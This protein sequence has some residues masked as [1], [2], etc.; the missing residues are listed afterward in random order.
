MSPSD[1]YSPA[2]DPNLG[3]A[4]LTQRSRSH[5]IARGESIWPETPDSSF[6]STAGL[7]DTDSQVLNHP[8]TV[9]PLQRRGSLGLSGL[10]PAYAP[11][12]YVDSPDP[13]AQ[14]LRLT[15]ENEALRH[16]NYE[17]ALNLSKLRGSHEELTRAYTGLLQVVSTL[18][19]SAARK[20]SAGTEDSTEEAEDS[21]VVP[22]K[23]GR[24]GQA[25]FST[26][27]KFEAW[28]KSQ[29]GAS[30]INV[31]HQESGEGE[32]GVDDDS[33]GKQCRYLED[34]QGQTLSRVRVDRMRDH[35]RAI[36]NHF[37]VSG[38]AP[39][40]WSQAPLDVRNEFRTEMV[41]RF[42]ELR[43][44]EDDWKTD[45]LATKNYPNWHKRR[46]PKTTVI[47]DEHHGHS[48]RAKRTATSSSLTDSED[49][50][51][52]M[53]KKAKVADTEPTESLHDGIA[54][55][56]AIDK[57]KGPDV[58][59]KET[60]TEPTLQNRI[61][62]HPVVD[63]GKRPALVLKNVLSGLFK[64]SSPGVDT[65]P[66]P[67]EPT[68]TSNTGT[69]TSAMI[70]S[71]PAPTTSLAANAALVDTGEASIPPTCEPNTP[72][73]VLLPATSTSS[74]KLE[75][76]PVQPTT[77]SGSAKAGATNVKIYKPSLSTTAR[78]LCGI[79]WKKK[80]PTG[81]TEDFAN[82]YNGL[83]PGA[84]K[85]FT[86]QSKQLKAAAKLAAPGDNSLSQVED[87]QEIDT[88]MSQ[89]DSALA[90]LAATAA[91]VAAV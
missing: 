33:G 77:K 73:D 81:T 4:A 39:A 9:S 49:L 57:G 29:R 76:S 86:E 51:V 16:E 75:Q 67:D 60:G 65:G 1:M 43:L 63:K 26:R 21:T 87:S 61:A 25:K 24:Y 31:A 91:E 37:A 68:G 7:D 85:A 89:G 59:A 42:P 54:T 19:V 22:V 32:E 53:P 40:T 74:G 44:C 66:L 41:S 28:R 5:S 82:Y 84:R 47:K 6:F 90:C 35:A 15:A 46:Y 55:N 13:R 72:P 2:L 23:S 88:P 71:I 36:W 80:N 62:G 50:P 70:G 14:M 83:L 30:D 17:N 18:Q 11:G 10:S 52:Q 79:E 27:E 58:I 56:V 34:D 78:N 48:S 20:S 64:V 69:L 38:R 45:Y 12:G 8:H 3:H